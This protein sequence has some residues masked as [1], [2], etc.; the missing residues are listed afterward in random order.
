MTAIVTAPA[1]ADTHPPLSLFAGDDWSIDATFLDAAGAPIDLTGATV[2]WTLLNIE[3]QAALTSSQF[4]ITLGGATGQATV[5][6]ASASS[7][8][9]A[10]GTYN[11]AWRL[12]IGSVTTTALYGSFIIHADP[13]AAAPAVARFSSAPAGLSSRM[14]IA[15]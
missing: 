4:S 13:F 11:D 15:A 3:G 5:K 1:V 12:V 9:L 2:L 10:G 8:V 6:V 14:R 7:T